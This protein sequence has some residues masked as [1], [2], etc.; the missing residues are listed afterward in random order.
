[1]LY[2]H[3]NGTW[4][5]DIC[6]ERGKRI[7]RSTRTTD[8]KLAEELH[9]KVKHE[10]WR[11]EFLGDKKVYYWDEAC[12]R[13][14]KEMEHKKTLHDDI[15]KI[16]KLKPFRGLELTAL[17]RQFIQDTVSNIEGKNSTKNRYLA[18]IRSILNKCVYEWEWLDR[19]PK[20]KLYKEPKRRIR[21]LTPFE[22][23]KLSNALPRYLSEI[24][25]F[26]VS[27]GLRKT[28]VIDLKWEQIDLDRRVAWVDGSETKSGYSLGCALNS[29]AFDIL[30]KQLGKHDEFVFT[31]SKNRP[32]K[33]IPH[34]IWKR[35]LIRSG[36]KDF[37]WH[38]L[39]H[40]WA[41]WLVQ[42]GVSLSVLQE[43]GGWESIE[44]VQR[45]AHLAPEHLQECSTK[46][47]FAWQKKGTSKN[48]TIST[49]KKYSATL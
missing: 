39:R 35:A 21:W 25:I 22:V 19:A 7:R 36:I 31:N 6:T 20:L 9:D 48:E 44:M 41:S 37:R 23:E 2:K 27:T 43:M 16:K 3:K 14:I 4:Y 34:K 32:I 45:Y 29:T 47:D 12:S 13:W 33:Q 26:S 18:F 49:N 8:K 5:I 24:M 40:T 46:I 30:K 11:Q 38:D 42:N 15:T 28:N 17:N 10:L 1:M